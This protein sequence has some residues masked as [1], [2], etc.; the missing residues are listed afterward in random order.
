MAQALSEEEFHRM[1]AQLLELRTQNY[2]LSDDLRKN[3]TE[4]NSVHL[5]TVTL[6]KD[7]IK[8]QKALNKSKKAQEVDALLSENEMLQGKLHSQED[9]FRLQNS[10]L[11]QELSKLCTQIEEL[12]HEIKELKDCKGLQAESSGPISISVDGELLR[13]QAE[14]AALQ[15]KMTALQE[16]HESEI[17]SP[18]GAEVSETKTSATD[19]PADTNG[20]RLHSDV[21]ESRED[22]A[23]RTNDRLEQAEAKCA[24]LEQRVTE[25]SEVELQ[26]H[27]EV[28]EKRLLKEQLH[29]LESSKQADITQLQEEIAKLSDKLKKKQD[30]FLRSQAEKEVLYNDSRT[31]IDE[32]QQR[33]EEE[34][35]SLKIRIQKLQGDLLSANQSVG[36]M[37]EQL[38]S[39]QKEH[40]LVLHTLRD[41]IACQSAVSQEQVEGILTEND[42]LR[43]NLVALEQIQTV[44]TQE[45][46]L[47]RDQNMALN[48]ELQQRRT[49]QE[50]FLAQRD[51]L[52]SQLQEVNRAN[53][54]L[55]EQ[56]TELDQWKDRLQQELEEA[57]KTADKRKAMLDELAMEIITEKSRHKE[58][59]SDVR[60]QHEK[61]VLG[62]RARYEKELRGLHEDKNRTEEGIRSQL[63]DEKARNKELE[64]LQQCVEELQAQV[65]SM[66]DTKGWFERRLKDAEESMEKSCLEH[67][68]S[69][70]KLQEEHSLQLKGKASDIDGVNLQLTEV[71][72][73]R[74]VHIETIGKLKQ[75][76]KD[77]VDG[78]RI[79]EKK[80]SSALK[81][82]KRQL[83]LE[84]KR[85]DKLQERLQEILTNTKTRTGL[86]ELVLSEISSPSPKQQRGDSSSVSSFSYGEI[87]KE[88]ATSQSINK[89]A[90]GSPQSQRPAD[91]SDDEVGELFQRL[92]GVQQEKWMLEEKVKHLEVS[93]SS[94]ADDICKKSAIIETYVM[95]SRI[96]H[97]AHGATAV[98]HHVG[99]VGGHGHGLGSVLRDLV[100]P[101]DENLREMNKKLQNMLEEQLT[102]NM[103][104][105]KDLEVLSQEIVHLSKDSSPGA[106]SA[107]G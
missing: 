31:K 27:T 38:Q 32:I 24:K 92:A 69:T 75:E 59:L 6:E 33:K 81:D 20:V 88:G 70:E 4:L 13:L 93:C 1:Q 107:T 52:N 41:Q 22:S 47:L 18:R 82:L 2:Q 43:T 91:L 72:K 89:S 40:D 45:M 73:E 29:A 12:Q 25:L 15:K 35:K 85:A 30:S 39:R 99:Q 34:L 66:E 95:D 55:L 83:Q 61:E 105:Q 48:V 57:K 104:L 53:S 78:Q 23:A 103:H 97:G 3:T 26:L 7:Y 54:R 60:L 36:E 84:R 65:Q 21:S 17:K 16:R 42:A 49:E 68:E 87:M 90:S 86:E 50:S 19:G 71:E 79:L 94:M 64:G 11:M 63:R 62:V 67:Q 10:T 96:A 98:A 37:K 80:G 106:G 5:K 51:D 101:G 102:K 8:A 46:N 74:D 9:D 100:K 77:T 28:E 56:L 58:E 76:I 44:K 14:N